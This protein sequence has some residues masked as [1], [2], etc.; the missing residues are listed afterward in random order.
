MGIVVMV[1]F[2]QGKLSLFLHYLG[3]LLWGFTATLCQGKGV[4]SILRLLRVFL[5]SG[6][7]SFL[8]EPRQDGVTFPFFH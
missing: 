4:P 6:S 8:Y 7:F 3:C 2:S 1:P 5:M